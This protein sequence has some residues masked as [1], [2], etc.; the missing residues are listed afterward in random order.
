[1]R[2][3]I[4][5][6]VHELARQDERVVF[7][8]SDISKRDLAGFAEEFPD[9]YIMEGVY[10]QH[11][12]GLAAGLAMSGKIPYINTIA[13]FLTRRCYEQI[14]IDLCMHHQPVR[15]IGSGGG[16]VYAPLGG[17]HLAIE[18]MAILRSVPH[19]TVVA[20]SDAE[21]MTRF[22]PTTLDYPGPIYIRLAKGGDNVVPHD[23]SP[24]VIGKAYPKR[25]GQD[26]LLV[27][28]GT[29]TLRC[30][31]AAERLSAQ[32]LEAAVLHVPTVKPFDRET[33]LELAEPARAV[34]AV[35]EGV[36]NGGLGSAVAEAVLEANFPTPKRFARMGF[37]DT[38]LEHFGSQ[39][40]IMARYGLTPEGIAARVTELLA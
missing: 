12:I 11:V 13:T 27:G 21:E 23:G 38:F 30:L 18:D 16:T 19:M 26:A 32:G 9:R 7:I 37:P 24:F 20:C 5:R 25:Q 28:T 36:I 1:M 4:L 14:V 8:G 3:T 33:L 40:A 22:L 15:L 29:T 10:E 31:E 34:V 17:T 39:N 35:E 2:R 6:G